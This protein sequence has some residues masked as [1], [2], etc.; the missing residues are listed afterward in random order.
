M[1]INY[2]TN[3]TPWE[4]S[5]FVIKYE[6]V[7]LEKTE[8]FGD[9]HDEK[10]VSAHCG[11]DENGGNKFDITGVDLPDKYLLIVEMKSEYVP[12][13]FKN[14]LISMVYDKPTSHWTMEGRALSSSKDWGFYNPG[15]VVS[16]IIVKGL[17]CYANDPL[18]GRTS[19][20]DNLR[21]IAKSISDD[22][23]YIADNC[24][25]YN[26]PERGLGSFDLR[27]W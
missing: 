21:G 23:E 17:E 14:G 3:T 9:G 15:H 12:A 8:Q 19:L 6:G 18:V 4:P 24:L 2:D 22:S 27:P 1:T 13:I 5:S 11:V 16:E 26:N 25:H 20:N 7:D 10:Y